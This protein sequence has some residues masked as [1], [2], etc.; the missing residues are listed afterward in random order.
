MQLT[1][2]ELVTVFF[3]LLALGYALF[4]LMWY[5][6]HRVK[7]ANPQ[8]PARFQAVY[9]WKLHRKHYPHS[10]LPY[11]VLLC[12]I[13][14]FGFVLVGIGFVANDKPPNK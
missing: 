5:Q 11:A 12:V 10:F 6:A 7:P 1:D 9:Y 14:A 4:G 3:L 8:L 2:G 13:L